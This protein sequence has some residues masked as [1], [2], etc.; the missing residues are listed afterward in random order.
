MV[1][2]ALHLRHVYWEHLYNLA[3]CHNRVL[4]KLGGLLFGT[5]CHR[6]FAHRVQV[7]LGVV[8]F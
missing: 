3:C 2:A 8:A 1:S 5:G 6:A 4:H 7:G